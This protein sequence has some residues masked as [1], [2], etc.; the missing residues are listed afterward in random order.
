MFFS[1]L[2]IPSTYY[3]VDTHKK[4]A[5]L[6]RELLKSKLL[7]FDI[8]TNHPT[9]KSKDKVADW[10]ASEAH[11]LVAGIGYAWGRTAVETPWKTGIAAYVPLTRPDDTPYWG[12][13]QA[14]VHK[15][16]KD[17]QSSSTPKVAHNGKFDCSKLRAL[18]DIKTQAFTFD[19]ML[20]G[21][22]VD[23]EC[24]VST[25]AL[26]SKFSTQG[27]VTDL[28]MS[29]AYLD[30]GASAFK[31]DLDDALK[32]Y[33]PAL[34]R[35]SCVPLDILHPYGCADADLTLSLTFVMQKLMDAE[36][37]TWNFENIMMPLQHRLMLMEMHG[38]PLDILRA[39][40]VEADQTQIME[41]LTTE[42]H[43]LTGQV[44]NVSSTQQLGK[45]LFEDLKLAGGRRNKQGWVVDA[46]V[47]EDL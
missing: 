23:E 25:H 18:L 24:L 28:G 29:D 36:G 37:L 44:F 3:L 13:R 4:L 8:E 45:V 31:R 11:E 12:A 27:I 46:E 16:I 30:I 17:I 26:K 32:H 40:Q 2:K 19:T 6:H 22:L 38:V 1:D 15:V 5:W 41:S 39:R 43:A 33:D 20:A 34:K 7:A 47:I 14:A 42:I 21:A 10:K 9:T 35:Y